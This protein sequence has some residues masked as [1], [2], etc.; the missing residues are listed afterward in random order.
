MLGDMAKMMKEAKNV[1]SKMKKAQKELASVTVEGESKN[2]KVTCS[3]DGKMNV[4]GVKIDPS[5]AGDV[6]TIEKSVGEAVKNAIDKANDEAQKL[7][8]GVTG[9]LNIPGLF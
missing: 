8:S 1:Q 7:M 4:K 5:L 6:S 9:G 2:G 3:M